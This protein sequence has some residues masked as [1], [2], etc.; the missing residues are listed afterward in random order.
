MSGLI[1][2]LLLPTQFHI[3]GT[4]IL[5]LKDKRAFAKRV[6]RMTSFLPY[7]NGQSAVALVHKMT[8]MAK[9]VF[10]NQ[11]SIAATRGYFSL[12]RK[13]VLEPRSVR[14]AHIVRERIIKAMQADMHRK[15]VVPK[16]VSQYHAAARNSS[17]RKRTRDWCHPVTTNRYILR[18][19][20]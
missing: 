17:Y 11:F 13:H 15:R 5:R 20:G 12:L 1:H 4:K 16:Y 3:S 18:S 2:Y 7:V 14:Q 8:S 10:L 9:G 19:R 6:T